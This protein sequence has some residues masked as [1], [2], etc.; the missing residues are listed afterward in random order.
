[1]K[2]YLLFD[3]G[4]STCSALAQEIAEE[5]GDRLAVRSLRDSDIQAL[6]SQ[7]N[8]NWHWEPCLL[9]VSDEKVRVYTGIA[10]RTRLALR[11]GP[12][13]TRR[14]MSLVYRYAVSSRSPAPSDMD[15]RQ[16]LQQ[17][18]SLLGFAALISLGWPGF[19][20][21]GQRAMQVQPHDPHF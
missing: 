19:P 4:C 20:R 12:R 14:V 16:F 18:G 8:P 9:E 10:M 2:S 5:V 3:S 17:S 1:M 6:L 13:R 11:L 21:S 15:R 7:A